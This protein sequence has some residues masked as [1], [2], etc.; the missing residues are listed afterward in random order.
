M[1]PYRKSPMKLNASRSLIA[2]LLSVLV[3]PLSGG[4]AVAQQPAG[5][6]PLTTAPPGA[7]A[8]EPAVM[9]TLKRMSDLLK[10]AKSF[11]FSYRTARE[12]VAQTGQIVDFLHVARVALTRPN[13]LRI[14]ITGTL[15]N[16]IL[17]YDGKV[18]TLFD[19]TQ[20]FYSQIEAPPTI[21]DTLMRL[22][23]KYETSFP[24]AGVLLADPYEKMRDGLK[25]AVDLGVV[26]VDGIRVRHLLFGEDDAD[27]QLWVED[28]QRP[29]PRRLA[30]VYKKAPGAPR[31]AV[32]FS[33]WNL[34]PGV[35]SGRF[36]FVKPPQ[37]IQ[38][39]L[40]TAPPG[41]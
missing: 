2:L 29:L 14:D 38:V 6:A 31:V 22:M 11:T 30:I 17:R 16:T 21:D 12:Q 24:V 25:T 41:S 5:Q 8:L 36:V 26:N 40:K 9:E 35:P 28:G 33:D 19:P 37:A 7:A 1:A 23:D 32:T 18:V 4:S 3:A 34:S 10:G 15:W 39:E 13:K 27:W 20:R